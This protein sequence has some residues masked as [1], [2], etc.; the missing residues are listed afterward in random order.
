MHMA[1]VPDCMQRLGIFPCF[2][3][4]SERVTSAFQAVTK[5]LRPRLLKDSCTP[6]KVSNGLHSR[7]TC[8]QR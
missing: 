8:G 3:F 2:Y 1:L 4:T 6:T 5:V 7:L